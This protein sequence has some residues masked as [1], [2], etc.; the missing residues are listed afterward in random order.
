MGNTGSGPP[1]PEE[2]RIGTDGW[3]LWLP[4]RMSS[5]GSDVIV[6]WQQPKNHMFRPCS[7][8]ELPVVLWRG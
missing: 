2:P 1:I 6:G 8:G 4:P 5:S 7:P 3:A